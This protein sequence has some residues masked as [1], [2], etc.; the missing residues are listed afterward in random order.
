[1]ATAQPLPVELEPPKRAADPISMS[2]SVARCK[3]KENV[4]RTNKAHN[5]PAP[6]TPAHHRFSE[7]GW[8]AFFQ[9]SL[10]VTLRRVRCK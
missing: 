3:R 5:P 9:P 8:V 6:S 10:E 7:P 4:H 1:V 2:R